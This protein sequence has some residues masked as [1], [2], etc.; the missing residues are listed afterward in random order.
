MEAAQKS[1]KKLSEIRK[2]IDPLIPESKREEPFARKAL[3]AV[4]S[5]PGVTC[6]LNGM[7]HPV[8]VDDSL[9]ILKWEPL[10]Q[11]RALFGTIHTSKTP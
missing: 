3:W 9:T 5:I 7:R 1:A 11:P 6:V 10:S 2:L 8:Y 4:A